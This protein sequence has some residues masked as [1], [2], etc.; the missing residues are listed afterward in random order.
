MKTFILAAA[1]AGCLAAPASAK[2]FELPEA[3]PAVVVTLPNGW[4]PTETEHGVECNSPDNETYVS[5]ETATAK[6]MEA[7]IDDD[8]KYLVGAGVTINR[9]SQQSHDSTVNGMPVSYLQWTGTDKEGPTAVTLGIV[10]VSANLVMLI[11]AW[12]SP[13]GDKANG[14]QLDAILSSVKRR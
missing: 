1:I 12:S 13:A 3:N 2:T 5:V 7:L 11:T 9:K 6:G 10:G 4:K 8:L 14:A